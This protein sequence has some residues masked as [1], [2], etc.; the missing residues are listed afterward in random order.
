MKRLRALVQLPAPNR[1]GWH[2][3]IRMVLAALLANLATILVGLNH[4]YWAVITCLIIVQGSLGATIGAG[5]SRL[6]GTAAGVVLG[7]LGVLL[8]RLSLHLPEWLVL[9]IVITPA[10]LLVASRPVFRFAPFTAALVLLLAGSGDFTF[11]LDR[12][13]EIA[14]GCGIGILVSLFVL[15][16]RAT[17]VLVTHAATILEQLGEFAVVLLAGTDQPERQ[18]FEWKMRNAFA[19]IQNDLKEVDHERSVLLLRKDPFPERLVRHLQRLRTDVN[20]LG[21]ATAPPVEHDG[22]A[23]LGMAIRSYFKT[24][25]AALRGRTVVT[26]QDTLDQATTDGSA[27]TPLG[28]AIATLQHE[29]NDL[30]QTLSA[31]AAPA[32][33]E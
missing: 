32:S 7:A 12:V 29:L 18:G 22:Y 11:A 25:A 13:A 4:G 9:L 14:L 20:M 26:A 3:A 17:V 1:A 30:N 8:Q 23:E 21:R 31:R 15:P 33:D 27:A 6:A 2:Q 19:Q 24:L 5:I 16:E 10:A 28:F